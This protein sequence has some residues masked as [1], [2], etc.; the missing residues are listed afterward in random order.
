VKSSFQAI[1]SIIGASRS[2]V[3]VIAGQ[4][5]S[6]DLIQYTRGKITLVDLPGLEKMACE[7]YRVVRDQ[8]TNLTEYDQGSGCKVH[9]TEQDLTAS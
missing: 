1:L 5:Q 8:L 2:T 9:A 3:T 7:C 4:S 6:L